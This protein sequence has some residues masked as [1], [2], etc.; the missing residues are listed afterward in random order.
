MIELI[1]LE[2]KEKIGFSVILLNIYSKYRCPGQ[3]KK[4]ASVGQHSCWNC[5]ATKTQTTS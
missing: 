1:G 3:L 2:E 4:Y 5:D